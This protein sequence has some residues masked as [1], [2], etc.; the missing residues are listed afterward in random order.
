MLLH[1]CSPFNGLGSRNPAAATAAAAPAAA[2]ALAAAVGLTLLLCSVRAL[3]EA[4]EA[5]KLDPYQVVMFGVSEDMHESL[6]ASGALRRRAFPFKPSITVLEQKEKVGIQFTAENYWKCTTGGWFLR[7]RLSDPGPVESFDPY[8]LTSSIEYIDEATNGDS[9]MPSRLSLQP[10]N[11][12][13]FSPFMLR[14]EGDELEGAPGTLACVEEAQPLQLFKGWPMIV[15]TFPVGTWQRQVAVLSS[16]VKETPWDPSASPLFSNLT[17]RDGV[18]VHLTL[19]TLKSA[20]AASA[21]AEA[22]RPSQEGEELESRGRSGP[23]ALREGEVVTFLGLLKNEHEGSFLSKTQWLEELRRRFERA[24]ACMLYSSKESEAAGRMAAAEAGEEFQADVEEQVLQQLLQQAQQQQQDELPPVELETPAWVEPQ[25][26]NPAEKKEAHVV[27]LKCPEVP[28]VVNPPFESIL[29]SLSPS[30]K[31]AVQSTLRPYKRWKSPALLSA[32]L[33]SLSSLMLWGKGDSLARLGVPPHRVPRGPLDVRGQLSYAAGLASRTEQWVSNVLGE[34]PGGAFFG[35]DGHY[36]ETPNAAKSLSRSQRAGIVGGSVLS[37]LGLAAAVVTAVGLLSTALKAASKKLMQK[38]QEAVTKVIHKLPWHRG[39]SHNLDSYAHKF[40]QRHLEGESQRHVLLTVFKT[41]PTAIATGT[42]SSSS[43][44]EQQKLLALEG[45]ALINNYNRGLVSWLQERLAAQVVLPPVHVFR[46]PFSPV[47]QTVLGTRANMSVGD[48]VRALLAPHCRAKV[49]IH[50]SLLSYFSLAIVE[51]TSTTG[52]SLRRQRGRSST[53]SRASWACRGLE[54]GAGLRFLSPSLSMRSSLDQ[55]NAY[56]GAAH[57]I[58]TVGPHPPA[59]KKTPLAS[60]EAPLGS[61]VSSEE[62]EAPGRGGPGGFPSQPN[63]A[64]EPAAAL[65]EGQRGAASFPRERERELWVALRGHCL[66]FKRKVPLNISAASISLRLGLALAAP[67]ARGC[68]W[69]GSSP[70]SLVLLHV[71]QN[72]RVKAIMDALLAA[73]RAHGL[74]P[75]PELSVHPSYHTL[76]AA[77]AAAAVDTA[78]HEEAAAEEA[79]AGREIET[80]AASHT[81]DHAAAA[82]RAFISIPEGMNELALGLY[83]VGCPADEEE[84][85]KSFPSSPARMLWRRL[86]LRDSSGPELGSPSALRRIPYDTLAKDLLDE[87][88]FDGVYYGFVYLPHDASRDFELSGA[89]AKEESSTEQLVH[90]L[91]PNLAILDGAVFN[92]ATQDLSLGSKACPEDREGAQPYDLF[93]AQQS[94]QGRQL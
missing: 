78:V 47:K 81:H 60:P 33:F 20:S 16:L 89:E 50:P 83:V 93:T 88:G 41:N 26:S 40:L 43:N 38:T 92:F 86:I 44:A 21:A 66:L 25:G 17:N 80:L 63:K 61:G 68:R 55:L 39:T 62:S 19:K 15:S 37:S 85:Q 71:P 1:R 46:G 31:R 29:R 58:I 7:V 24:S 70:G 79:D 11:P 23:S 28:I 59:S 34:S 82:A 74:L 45:S 9:P 2:A 12:L 35:S 57:F 84:K 65:A 30:L 52:P 13:Q 67:Q 27:W 90:P 91:S 76:D 10:L 49:E 56:R 18:L 51:P 48:F 94:P 54:G 3:G 36:Y 42:G 87:H 75:S 69:P 72:V 6:A 53:G 64:V 22:L 73:F 32:I 14:A 4:L 77:A 8:P 5:P